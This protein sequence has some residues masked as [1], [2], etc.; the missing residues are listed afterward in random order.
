MVKP[1][2]VA[3][4]AREMNFYREYEPLLGPKNPVRDVRKSSFDR[5]GASSCYLWGLIP[6]CYTIETLCRA[7]YSNDERIQPAI[8][9]LLGVQRESGGWCRNLGG[10]PNCSIHA[11]HALGSHP[12]LR[13]STYAERA[14]RCIQAFN[15][16][17]FQP[18][19]LTKNLTK[20]DEFCRRASLM[21]AHIALFP[22]MWNIGYTFFDPSQPNA[23]EAWKAQAVDRDSRFVMHFRNLAKELHMAIAITYLEQWEGAPRNSVSIVNRHGEMLMTYA[24]VHT[25][26]FDI[27]SALTPGD[28]FYVCALDIGEAEVKI[29]AMICYDRE[30]PESARILMLK[31][32][33]IILTPNACTLEKNRIEQFRTRAY[34]NMLG[35]AMA[36][37]ASPKNNG[38]SIAFD[39]VAFYENEYGPDTLVI[40]AGEREGIYLAEFDMDKIRAY[41]KK[42]VWG[43]AFR[44]PGLYGLLISQNVEEPFIRKE[45][46]R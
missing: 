10:H 12:E 9:I 30:F 41:R 28:N 3:L 39:G 14:I 44:K 32:A 22:E 26:D 8:N 4:S 35:V 36:N 42:E 24:K 37:Y 16:F 46:R 33:E 25:C 7:G 31:G 43:N 20:G 11:I 38:H 15:F 18:K 5:V 21:G 1:D 29:G 6:L 27:E 13:Q 17:G 19:T 45:A 2:V 34:E 23:R 40:E